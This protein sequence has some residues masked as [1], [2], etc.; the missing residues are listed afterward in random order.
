MEGH[1]GIEVT[2]ASY[3]FFCDNKSKKLGL[4]TFS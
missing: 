1:K 4:V 3:N 2:V